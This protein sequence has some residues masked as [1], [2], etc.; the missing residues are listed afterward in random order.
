MTT[1]SVLGC[2][3]LVLAA[4]SVLQIALDGASFRAPDHQQWRA[5]THHQGAARLLRRNTNGIPAASPAAPFLSLSGQVVVGD[6]PGFLS[7]LLAG[8]F[9]PPRV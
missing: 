8:V 6:C 5:P 1:R 7:P 4:F 3:L 2:V 9:V